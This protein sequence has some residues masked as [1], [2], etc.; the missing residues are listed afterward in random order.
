MPTMV[1]NMQSRRAQ[2]AHLKAKIALSKAADK[3][4]RVLSQAYVFNLSLEVATQYNLCRFIDRSPLE[5]TS[6]KLRQSVL[7]L[8]TPSQRFEVSRFTNENYVPYYRISEVVAPYCK[9]EAW[10][11]GQ[12]E[13]PLKAEH[14]REV[15]KDDL[16]WNEFLWGV[17]S[18][19]IVLDEGQKEIACIKPLVNFLYRPKKQIKTNPSQVEK[20]ASEKSA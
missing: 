8:E 3:M 4:Y 1:D 19:K 13:V 14:T 2:K 12:E 7:Y 10:F 16:Q 17:D 11:E 5:R 9:D 20:Q 18:L 15:V 6:D